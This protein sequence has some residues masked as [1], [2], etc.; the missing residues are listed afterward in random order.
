MPLRITVIFQQSVVHAP[1]VLLTCQAAVTYYL[2]HAKPLLLCPLLLSCQFGQTVLEESVI[3]KQ[4][5][6]RL[7][8]LFVS[9][10]L[11]HES[12]SR[13]REKSRNIIKSLRMHELLCGAEFKFL[14][15]L[16]AI[17]AAILSLRE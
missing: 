6:K 3:F 4:N 1:Y 11:R 9:H 5:L 7:I 12:I 2:V 14:S 17:R 8:S 15:L 16:A 10:Q 13:V